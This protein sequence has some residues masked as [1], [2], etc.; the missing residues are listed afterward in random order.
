[1]PYQYCPIALGTQ[2]VHVFPI[3]FQLDPYASQNFKLPQSAVTAEAEIFA[4]L[5]KNG[6]YFMFFQVRDIKIGSK[7]VRI[8]KRRV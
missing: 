5:T 7:Y 3:Q 4:L 2:Y 6:F 1:M 8:H